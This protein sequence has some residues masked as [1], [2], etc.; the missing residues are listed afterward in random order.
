[1][2]CRPMACR[3]ECGVLPRMRASRQTSFQR[4]LISEG[5][6]RPGLLT[7]VAAGRNSAGLAWTAASRQ[8]LRA[9]ES[10]IAFRPFLLIA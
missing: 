2:T 9:R 7:T 6:R 5:V 3:A 8:R 1:M 10:A 4:R